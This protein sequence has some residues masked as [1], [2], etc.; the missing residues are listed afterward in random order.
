[1]HT[2]LCALLSI[3]VDL[4]QIPYFS[5]LFVLTAARDSISCALSMH[6]DAMP[7]NR[8][9][10]FFFQ[11][12]FFICVMKLPSI[13]LHLYNNRCYV[14]FFYSNSPAVLREYIGAAFLIEV[15]R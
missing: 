8:E 12:F 13:F 15:N 6:A 4:A 2:M 10:R 14:L 3:A 9:T 1:M 11:H 7:A 5:M